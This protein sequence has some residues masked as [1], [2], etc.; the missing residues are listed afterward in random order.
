MSNGCGGKTMLTTRHPVDFPYTRQEL[1]ALFRYAHAHDVEKGG[2]YD[3]RSAAINMWSHHWLND[4]TRQESEIIGSFY[5]HWA[6]TPMLYEIETDEGFALEDLMVELGRLELWALGR[7]KHGD[8]PP[9][10][11]TP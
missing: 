11:R 9:G 2:H 1:E 6:P 5:V 4:A 8:P 10:G 7:V 3:A